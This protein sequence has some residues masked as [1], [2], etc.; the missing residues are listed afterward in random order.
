MPTYPTPIPE[1]TPPAD[2]SNFTWTPPNL[3]EGGK[4]FLERIANLK[5]SCA[6]YQNTAEL[7]D[8]GLSR[9]NRHRLNYSA[10]GPDPSWLQLLWWEFPREH[11][12]DLR[13][14]FRQNFLV[15]PP[16][17]LTPNSDMSEAGLVAAGA[18]VDELLSLG[19]I[20]STEDGMK[21]LANA[22][23]FVV[24]KP[25]QPGQWRVIADMKEGG[26][27]DCIGSDP[28]FL[29][30][31]NHILEE[32]Y[33][34]GYSAVVDMSKYFYNIPTHPDDHP[35]LGLVHPITGALYTYF[36]LPMGSSS[37]PAFASRV[38]NSF[39]RRLR[40]KFGIF[41][42]VGSANCFWSS[43]EEL[44]YDPDRGYGFILTNQLGMAVKLWGFVD[45]FLIHGESLELCSQGLTL[46]L[47]FAVDC[48]FLAHPDK[49]IRPSQQVKYVGFLLNTVRQPTILIPKPKRERALAMVEHLLYSPRHSQFSRLSLAVAA[50]VLESIAEATPHR[51]GHTHLRPLHTLVHPPG[52]GTGITPYCTVTCLT[53]QVYDCLTWW[54][55]CLL[56]GQGRVVRPSKA[57]TLVPMFGDG[58]GTGTGGTISGEGQVRLMWSA[59]WNLRTYSFTSNWKE[60][61]TLKLALLHLRDFGD[62]EQLQGSSVFYFSD[63][64]V[65]YFI[66][67]SGS[68]PISV[69]HQLIKDII[70]LE[71]ELG[72]MLMVFHIPGDVMITQGTDSLSRGIWISNLH[73]LM[74][75]RSMLAAIFAPTT[76]DLSL[77][78]LIQDYLPSALPPF[79]YHDWKH[80]W[81]E[82]LCFGRLTVWC[83]PPE[84]GRQ[85]ITFLLNMWVEQPRTTSALII[86][87]RTCSAS[88]RG[89]SKYIWH[90]GTINPRDTLLHFPP[91]LPI[92]IEVLYL[93]PHTPCLS[94][95]FRLDTPAHPNSKWHKAQAEK[96]RWLPPVHIR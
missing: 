68:S 59:T 30:R 86:L 69:L 36:G 79:F 1:T 57:G 78:Y 73:E 28:V 58:S 29:P 80:P 77:M 61:N 83:P 35:F 81:D 38:G 51:M 60:L 76:F 11:W 65:T 3:Q 42:G 34:G 84:L 23:L 52:S 50:G 82:E 17:T 91:L 2:P 6:T 7:V 45:D 12:E 37:S 72:I 95:S 74:T 5:T 15:P 39:L 44:G 67:S 24:E 25:G 4:W 22:P 32:M 94:S 21:M 89:L 54:K 18:F 43:F 75:E 10:T 90:V 85:V 48:G 26:Q 49:L 13:N 41:S 55:Q 27:N 96:M 31:A 66:A 64:M 71:I 70:L 46:F 87:P 9:L 62:R 53:P 19:A 63:N 56:L 33:T 20:R 8:D 47:D 40:K 16:T 93:P 88:Y 92:P 14:G